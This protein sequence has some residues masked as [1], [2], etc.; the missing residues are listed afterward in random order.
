VDVGRPAFLVGTVVITD[1][2]RYGAY[3]AA[4]K[5][6]SAE[7][8]GESVVSGAVSDVLEGEGKAG[9]RVVVTKFPTEADARAYLTSP[10]YL[11]GKALRTGAG[12]VHLRLL[13]T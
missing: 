12:D 3:I 8:G 4:I 2:E 10:R 9:E 5:G 11:A 6:L 13:V 7:F 1:P